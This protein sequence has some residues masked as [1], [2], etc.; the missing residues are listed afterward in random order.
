MAELV[1]HR[2][3]T[4]VKNLIGLVINICHW[5]TVGVWCS[6]LVQ[7][8]VLVLHHQSQAG[9]GTTWAEHS[10]H[11]YMRIHKYTYTYTYTLD[12]N[13]LYYIHNTYFSWNLCHNW[14]WTHYMI[15]RNRRRK[16]GKLWKGGDCDDLNS[17]FTSLDST[18]SDND[19]AGSLPTT[20]FATA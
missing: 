5:L 12:K 9:L 6:Q 16:G 17:T 19:G 20:Q 15:Q 3:W 13:T 10:V 8:V 2:P 11:K 14:C 4:N 7:L 1:E 18:E